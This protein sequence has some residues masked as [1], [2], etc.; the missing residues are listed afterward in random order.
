MITLGQG[1][2]QLGGGNYAQAERALRFAITSEPALLMGRYDLVGMLGETR[3]KFLA[4]DLKELAATS[5][6]EERPRLLLAFLSYNMGN[7]PDAEKDVGEAAKLAPNDPVVQAMQKTWAV[8]P[9]PAAA[10]APAEP[11]K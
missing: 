9:A 11:N 3:A 5:P 4:K 7:G 2:A 10:P 6:K 8:L 1:I